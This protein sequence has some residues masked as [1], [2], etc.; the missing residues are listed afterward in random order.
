MTIDLSSPTF[1][2]VTID[3][4]AVHFGSVRVAYPFCIIHEDEADE[5]HIGPDGKC[6]P[7]GVVLVIQVSSVTWMEVYSSFDALRRAVKGSGITRN[8][9]IKPPQG[10][11]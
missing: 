6:C 8:T 5:S 11:D 4:T 9:D 1:A 3:G 7:N 10:Y 2:I